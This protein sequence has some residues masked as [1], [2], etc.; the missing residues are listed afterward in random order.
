MVGI[1][2][3]FILLVKKT[4]MTPSKPPKICYITSY[5]LIPEDVVILWIINK[6]V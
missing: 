1:M 6:A 5:T 3:I 2:P 4:D